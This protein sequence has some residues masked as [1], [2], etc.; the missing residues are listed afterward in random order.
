MLGRARFLQR[1]RGTRHI[2]RHRAE[3]ILCSHGDKTPVWVSPGTCSRGQAHQPLHSKVFQ[4][5]HSTRHDPRTDSAPD[6]HLGFSHSLAMFKTHFL[7]KPSRERQ[8]NQLTVNAAAKPPLTWAVRSRD[9]PV[10]DS[11]SPSPCRQPQLCPPALPGVW[12][13][14]DPQRACSGAEGGLQMGPPAW[15]WARATQLLSPPTCPLIPGMQE[16][17]PSKAQKNSPKW[18][19]ST[20]FLNNFIISWWT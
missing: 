12:C 18:R 20:E 15:F 16:R 1:F 10:I 14:R 4:V 13:H 5:Y 3:T 7:G 19:H 6:A 17:S 8:R 9:A 2:W 11:P